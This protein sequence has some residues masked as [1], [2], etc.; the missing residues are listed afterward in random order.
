VSD[1]A[2]LSVDAMLARARAETS[3]SDF[4]EPEYIDALRRLVA[5][6]RSD[7]SLSDAAAAGFAEEVNRLLVN[8]LRFAA[9]LQRHPEILEEDVSDPVIVIGLPRTGT[10]KLQRLLSA[11]PGVQRLDYWRLL[12][13][14]PLPGV[15]AQADDPRIAIARQ[16][17]ALM[18]QAA[19]EFL[20]GHP[21]FADQPDE[22]TFLQLF[23]FTTVL[24]Y[25]LH[26]A[27]GY[28]DWLKTQSLRGT[29][30]YVKRL[31]Q[32][33]QW[34]D[35]GKRGRPLIMKSPLHVGHL[36]LLSELYPH[37]TFVFTHRAYHEAIASYCRLVEM[38]WRLKMNAI[39]TRSLGAFAA[40]FWSG[41]LRKHVAQRKALGARVDVYDVRYEELCSDPMPV[42]REIY[43][44]AGR[45]LTPQ[46]ISAMQAWERNNPAGHYGTF[47]YRL[48]DYGLTR[49]GI[50]AAFGE[51]DRY[52]GSAWESVHG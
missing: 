7:M 52:F 21:F 44:R 27:Q 18:Q 2:T 10:T 8:R 22:D 42:I 6:T 47:R 28:L 3:L 37:A 51:F 48:E 24:M 41:E 29:Y 45:T 43:R 5:A 25:H 20:A 50:D 11:D 13:P 19:P 16:M 14:A 4:G 38:G 33:L 46:A 9:D 31:L 35:G 15:P 40:A 34:Q 32:Y 26:P 1:S 17:V 36:D 39:D 23:T 30:V 12:N 49:A